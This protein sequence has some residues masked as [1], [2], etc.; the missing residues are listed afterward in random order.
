[1]IVYIYRA[2]RSPLF[3]NKKAKANWNLRKESEA[4]A[5]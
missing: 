5:T 4:E 3:F 1:M 2:V